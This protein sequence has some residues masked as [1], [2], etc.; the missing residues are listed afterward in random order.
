MF[1]LFFQSVVSHLLG[2]NGVSL[3]HSD[4]ISSGMMLYTGLWQTDKKTLPPT[5]VHVCI[6]A[7]TRFDKPV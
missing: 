4:I 1:S 2:Y 5:V 7:E 3:V 6:L